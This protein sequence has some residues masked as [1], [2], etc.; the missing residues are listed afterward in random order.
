MKALIIILILAA[1][2]QTTI[3]PVDFVLLI[4]IC[5][6]YVR[7]EK[8]NLSL[9]FAFG[10]LTAHLSLIS[11][12][13]YSIIYLVIV[14]AV[15]ILSRSNLAGNPLLIVPISMIL[16]TLSEFINSVLTNTTMEFSGVIIAALLSLP[17][18][19]LVKLW[20]ERFIVRKEIKLRV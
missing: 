3:L 7:S 13:L 18:F 15:Q 16:L 17:A 9:A 8:E 4:L 6:A 19:Y 2:L 11:L 5:R 14:Q 1:F 20:E 10:L 12:G